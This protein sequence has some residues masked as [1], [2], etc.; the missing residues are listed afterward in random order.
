MVVPLLQNIALLLA[1]VVGY[2]MLSE[3]L[4][5][6]RW[7]GHLL[8]GI[9]FGSIAIIGMMTP[10][11]FAPG[12]V[13]DGRSIVLA[14][15]GYI[16]G[17]TTA[18]TAAL[19]ATAYR[20]HLGGVGALPG[21][22]TIVTSAGFGAA[23]WRLRRRHR[24]RLAGAITPGV[25]AGEAGSILLLGI[26]VHVVMILVQ[27]LLP[28]RIGFVVARRF[29][30][31]II[32]AYPA[33]LFLT[34]QVFRLRED[35]RL[36]MKDLAESEGRYRA[37]FHNRH[38]PMLLLRPDDG[39]IVDANE[40]AAD[41]YGW[42]QEELRGM[43]AADINVLSA[44][45]TRSEIE[46][47][48]ARESVTFEFRHRSRNGRIIDVSITSGRV[49]VGG[50][51]LL[52]SIIEN[53]TERKRH[54]R[55]LYLLEY[56]LEESAVAVF[57]TGLP[58]GVVYYANRRASEL[59]GYSR[60]ELYGMT[61]FDID[62]AT[63]PVSWIDLGDPRG[64][65]A[66]RAFETVHFRKD[67]GEVPVEVT[68]S[69]MEYEGE[70]FVVV[71]AMDIT[72]RKRAEVAL[73]HS[74]AENRILLREVHHRVRNNLA[75]VNS[76]ISLQ[77]ASIR[78]PEGYRVAME[79]TRDRLVVMG[80]IHDRLYQERDFSRIDFPDFI[81][82]AA[83][84]LATEYAR[85]DEQPQ[86]ITTASVA[87]PLDVT[88]ALPLG[89]I[90]SEVITNSLVHAFVGRSPGTISITVDGTGPSADG[91]EGRRITVSDDGVGIRR[92]F[93]P[94]GDGG[95]GYQLVL[96]LADQIDAGVSVQPGESEG[97]VVVITLDETISP[98]QPAG[99]G[100]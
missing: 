72:E 97:T 82:H 94:A 17:P 58:D 15:A 38:A 81:D 25:R 63:T 24:G 55:E 95:L 35:R 98:A 29:G 60:E 64:D 48:R 40:A 96:S 77:M 84:H 47:A 83:A 91:E 22:L 44:E 93:D 31:T 62:P 27:L 46:R 78:T 56:S 42:S 8:H 16:A 59:L 53:I 79:K 23:A 2:D 19:I 7:W 14:A 88:R 10:V 39:T 87:L 1:L 4:P 76:L 90:L 71:F 33:A 74:L 51:E 57:R 9:L 85:E 68:V 43:R 21:V 80:M 65:S 34:L 69:R 28:D 41:L 49:L 30:P 37:L 13:Y 89:I 67:G 20:L 61:M 73:Q 26:V 36:A 52:Y 32:V 11:T 3:Y 99:D 66:S 6:R 45:E 50:E 12:V 54:A 92:G 100:T 18:A 70:E 86:I 75:V 5:S